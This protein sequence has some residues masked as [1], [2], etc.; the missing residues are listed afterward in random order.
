MCI[1]GQAPPDV[2]AYWTAPASRET[3]ETLER[4]ELGTNPAPEFGVTNPNAGGRGQGGRGGFGQGGGFNRDDWFKTEGVAGAVRPE[5][6]GPGDFTARGSAGRR[7]AGGHRPGPSP[8][9]QRLA[10]APSVSHRLSR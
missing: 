10:H 8:Q 2:A 5:P 4:M 3:P 6:P 1:L 7:P 9:G